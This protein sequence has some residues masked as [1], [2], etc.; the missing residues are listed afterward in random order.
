[1]KMFSNK[2]MFGIC[3]FGLGYMMPLLWIYNPSFFA[4]GFVISCMIV[5]IVFIILYWRAIKDESKN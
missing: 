2:F 1:M 4:K 3:C 5:E